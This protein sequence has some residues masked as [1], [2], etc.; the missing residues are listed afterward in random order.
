MSISFSRPDS[1]RGVHQIPPAVEISVTAVALPGA[2]LE[3][4]RDRGL[5]LVGAARRDVHV[6]EHEH[7]RAPARSS[8]VVLRVTLGGGGRRR[9]R[10]VGQDSTASKLET[11]WG[12]PSSSDGDVPPLAGP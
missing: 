8:G 10:L 7:E 6:V 9:G 1:M 3:E 11:V 2:L 12:T 5:R 4:A